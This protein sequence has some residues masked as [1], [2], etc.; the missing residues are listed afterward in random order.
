MKTLAVILTLLSLSVVSLPASAH[1]DV[2][3]YKYYDGCCDVVKVVKVV[4]TVRH[5]HHK[6]WCCPVVCPVVR[7][8]CW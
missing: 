2:Y 1:T 3:R 5:V 6:N 7:D 8:C 4:K